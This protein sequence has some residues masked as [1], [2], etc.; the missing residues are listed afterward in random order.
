MH[1]QVGADCRAHRLRRLQ[2]RQ[3]GRAARDMPANEKAP[4]RVD[5]A[6]RESR[7]QVFGAIVVHG[8]F[9]LAIHALRNASLA[10][11]RR[12]ITVPAG[13]PVTAAMSL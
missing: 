5:L 4:D 13:M 12:D 10:R 8:F 3:T 7:Q 1:R 11:D 9:S 2:L 6:I